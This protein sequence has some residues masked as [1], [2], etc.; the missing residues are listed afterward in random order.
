MNF[1]SFVFYLP[2]KM[3]LLVILFS[4]KLLAQVNMFKTVDT[5]T[6]FQREKDC[7]S[8]PQ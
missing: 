1:R 6:V 4:I 7:L 8:G 5:F 2:F 3:L